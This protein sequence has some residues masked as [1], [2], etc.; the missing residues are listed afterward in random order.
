M[1]RVSLEQVGLYYVEKERGTKEEIF[2]G[3]EW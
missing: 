2:Y 1:Q 3:M